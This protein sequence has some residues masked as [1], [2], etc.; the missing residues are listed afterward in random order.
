[1]RLRTWQPGEVIVRR[2]VWRGKPR[3]A[4]PVFVVRDEP[5]LLVTYIAE[6]APFGFPEQDPT[7]RPHPYSNRGGWQGNGVLCLHR[8]DDAYAVMVFWKGEH[9]DFWGWYINFQDPYRRTPIGFDTHDREVDL[10][11][12]DGVT[13]HRKD[14]ER[15]QL[16]VVKGTYTPEEAAEVL[17]DAQRV[18]AELLAGKRW[19]DDSWTR[20][21][22]SDDWPQPTL[23]EGWEKM[24]TS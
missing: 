6:S 7:G 3:M 12:E 19:W 14:F 11:S 15:L 23:P 17:A 24:K 10:W 21:A 18:E 20:W 5:D 2:E 22:P 1:M 16:R 4:L 8:S 13:W 9:R